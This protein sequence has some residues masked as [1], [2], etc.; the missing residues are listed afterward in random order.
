M[1][2]DKRS[3]LHRL[4][5]RLGRADDVHF[6][7][8]MPAAAQVVLQGGGHRFLDPQLIRT[9]LLMETGTCQRLRRSVAFV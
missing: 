2:A 5:D 4:A 6:L 9:P 8:D 7:Q 3:V 1:G